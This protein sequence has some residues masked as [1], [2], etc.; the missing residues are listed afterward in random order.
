MKL[1]QPGIDLIVQFEGFTPYAYDDPIGLCTAGPGILLHR[2]QCGPADYDRYGTRANPKISR[3]RYFLMLHDYTEGTLEFLEHV[4]K[5]PLA[6]PQVNA[7]VSFVHNIGEGGFTSSTVLRELNQRHY[8]KAAQAMLMWTNAG[9]Q[10]LAGLVRRRQAEMEMFLRGVAGPVTFTNAEKT[11]MRRFSNYL[12]TDRVIEP[13]ELRLR[14]RL[15]V[16]AVLIRKA[17]EREVGGWEKYDRRR[18]YRAIVR[19][20]R[21]TP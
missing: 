9:G 12:D 1:T 8:K 4:V 5:V 13:R 18:R 2:S 10:T 15:H 6:Q 7:L 17:A 11:L 20:L 14:D 21:R 16:Q 19:L 3:S